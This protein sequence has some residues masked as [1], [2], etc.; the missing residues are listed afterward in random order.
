MPTTSERNQFR[1]LIGDFGTGNVIDGDVDLYL[2]DAT[3]ELTADFTNS[4]MVSAPLTDFDDLVAQYKPEVIVWAAI[5]WWWNVASKLVQ[6]HTQ[7]IGQSSQ[8]ASEKWD[9]A[10]RM[11]E[12][13]TERFSEIQTLGTDITIGHLSRFSK[14]DMRRHGGQREESALEY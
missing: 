10:M 13:L 12:I 7:T 6:H 9:R 3:A 5:Q 8:T 14:S 2:N 1:K 11:I 4:S